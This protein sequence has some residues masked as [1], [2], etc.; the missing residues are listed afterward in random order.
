MVGFSSATPSV[1]T[2]ATHAPD[3]TVQ[4][5]QQTES[6][7]SSSRV[8]RSPFVTVN[9]FIPQTAYRLVSVPPMP[10]LAPPKVNWARKMRFAAPF[11]MPV[12]SGFMASALRPPPPP[13]F[14]N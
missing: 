5:A 9:P 13:G 6:V 1:T 4:A 14:Q 10:L 3:I 7:G 11:E 8:T 12:A 2:A